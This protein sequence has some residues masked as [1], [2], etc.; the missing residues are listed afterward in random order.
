MG[1]ERTSRNTEMPGKSRQS[2]RLMAATWSCPVLSRND[3]TRDDEQ[4][5][6]DNDVLGGFNLYDVPPYMGQ[7]EVELMLLG[8]RQLYNLTSGLV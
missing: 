1:I 5:L 3:R 7:K 2:C 4:L 6:T 8:E